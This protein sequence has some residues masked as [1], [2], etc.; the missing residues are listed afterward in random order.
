[1]YITYLL[2]TYNLESESVGCPNNSTNFAAL[3]RSNISTI[4]RMATG[5]VRTWITG[6]RRLVS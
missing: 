6:P 5:S 3:L 2:N 4:E 1:M